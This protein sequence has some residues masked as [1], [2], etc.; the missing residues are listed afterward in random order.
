MAAAGRCSA[1]SDRPFAF[2]RGR[3]AFPYDG[4]GRNLILAFKHADR[5]NLARALAPH[6]A[7][8]GADVLGGTSL[9][10]PVPLHRWLLLRRGYNQAALLAREIGRIVA[11]PTGLDALWR[12]RPTASLDKRGAEE[13]RAVVA[14]AFALGPGRS[15]MVRN[16]AV[17]VIDDVM[18]S[19]ATLDACASVLLRAG[20]D[21]VD[22]L[23]AARM[24]LS[25]AA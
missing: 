20:A 7:R 9:L 8:A 22:V 14:G 3:A 24:P 16:R 23:V 11:C 17:V 18:T 15:D 5:P 21:R 1:C 13:R 4:T 2:G 6:M 10:V 25:S 12:V 19:G